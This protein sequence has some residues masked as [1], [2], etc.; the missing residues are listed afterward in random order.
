MSQLLSIHILKQLY[1]KIASTFEKLIVNS[2]IN[3]Q[4]VQDDLSIEKIKIMK[5]S[6]NFRKL[7]IL[8]VNQ[9]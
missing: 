4:F 8:K 5:V 9:D 2:A 3:N 6:V 7:F 1:H